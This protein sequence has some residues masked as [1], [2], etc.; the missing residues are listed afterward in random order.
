ML[1]QQLYAIKK[2]ARKQ[3]SKYSPAKSKKKTAKTDKTRQLLISPDKK[4]EIN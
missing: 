4:K 3:I 2:L 1:L